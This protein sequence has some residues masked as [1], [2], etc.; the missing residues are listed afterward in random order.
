LQYINL[1]VTTHAPVAVHLT[2]PLHVQVT[3]Y[4]E[5]EEGV[6]VHFSGKTPPRRAKLLVGA[7][8]YFSKVR[9]QCLDDGPP[10]FV[11]SCTHCDCYKVLQTYHLTARKERKKSHFGSLFRQQPRAKSIRHSPEGRK[12]ISI[13]WWIRN[14]SRYEYL[15]KY[16]IKMCM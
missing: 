10:D 1:S 15:V 12:K 4:E 14:I 13:Q 9:S 3:H 5:D 16:Q 2:K 6:T 7:D 8:G 11:V